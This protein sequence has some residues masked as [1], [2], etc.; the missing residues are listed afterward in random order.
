MT[1]FGKKL[2]TML[3]AG[4]LA[5]AGIVGCAPS[6]P[7]T[8]QVASTADLIE[9]YNSKA[10]V[11]NYHMDLTMD[12]ALTDGSQNAT[13]MDVTCA[14]DVDKMNTHGT[15]SIEAMGQNIDTEVY[16]ESG[17]TSYMQY[18]GMDYN[19]QK[20]WLKQENQGNFLT[21]SMTDISGL[22]N[23]TFA[24]TDTGYT[25]TADG[26]QMLDAVSSLTGSD[27]LAG[28][29]PEMV[30]QVLAGSKITYA[31]DKECTLTGVS[32]TMAVDIEGNHMELTFDGKMSNHGKVDPA[33]VAVPDDVKSGAIDATA[34]TG[35][36][37]ATPSTTGTSSVA[38][39]A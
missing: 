38:A 10:A 29:D 31:F 20:M 14:F 11:D 5:L 18:I 35:G 22:S 9:Q 3:V 32:M 39:A 17:Q 13:N 7:A 33:T 24:A 26:S 12:I 23:A 28:V 30:K 16:A 2:A 15:M 1:T 4:S 36:A 27:L 37:A 19:G 25:L 8:P 6:T 34:L 21:G